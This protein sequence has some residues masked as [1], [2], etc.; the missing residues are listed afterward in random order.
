MKKEK[1][2]LSKGINWIKKL[3]ES[4]SK[5]QVNAMEMNGLG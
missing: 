2:K 1:K 4:L 5:I 3:Y